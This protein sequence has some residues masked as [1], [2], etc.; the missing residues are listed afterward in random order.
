MTVSRSSPKLTRSSP[1]ICGATD[2][3]HT[4]IKIQDSHLTIASHVPAIAAASRRALKAAA[5][6]VELY[7]GRLEDCAI[8]SGG[9]PPA[10]VY[11]PSAR[12]LLIPTCADRPLLLSE[13]EELV[14]DVQQDALIVRLSTWPNAAD[15]VTFDVLLR[16]HWEVEVRTGYRPCRFETRQGLWLA[17]AAGAD[18]GLHVSREGLRNSR[19]PATALAPDV[20][21][22]MAAAQR[23]FR[24]RIWGGL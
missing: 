15:L 6:T 7:G 1:N 18:T 3:R 4:A 22:G 11:D 12:I 8:G 14:R 19:Q 17:G 20:D 21:A 10:C 2:P 13:A 23:F 5:L 9:L 24:S 16:Q